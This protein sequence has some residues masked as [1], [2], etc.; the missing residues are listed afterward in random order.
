MRV[1]Y[2]SP[3][4]PERSGIADYSAELL[5]HLAA[6]CELE[7]GLAD[8]VEAD[9]ETTRGLPV[10]RPAE[11]AERLARGDYDVALYQI[12]NDG[13]FHGWIYDLAL[14]YPGVAVLHEVV[15]H[16]LVRHRT[17][18]RGDRAGYV[19]AMRYSYGRGGELAGRRA[20]DTGVPAD[21][22]AFPLFEPIADRSRALLVHNEYC[23]TRI[24]RSRTGARIAVVPHHL[25]LAAPEGVEL[26]SA[27]AR[28]ALGIRPDE[29]VVATFGY[30]TPAKRLEALLRAFAGL[31]AAMPGARL[32]IVGEI[33]P[34]YDIR[35]SEEARQP[36]VTWVGRS[37]LGTFLQW[38]AAADIAV[39]L[40][41]P[42]GGETSGTFVRLLG[43]GKPVIAT[44]AGAFAEVPAGCCALVD[45]GG[46]EVEVVTALLEL[47]ARRADLRRDMGDNARRLAAAWTLEASAAAYDGWLRRC[48]AENWQPRPILPPLAPT[49]SDDVATEVL[50][51]TAAAATDLGVDETDDELLQALALPMTDLNLDNWGQVLK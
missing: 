13:N 2:A 10:R 7:L 37:E 50:T 46:D 11:L 31:R 12:G 21:P 25:S 38:M 23:R 24:Q 4:A 45:P 17:L 35:G 5:P 49:N 14:R 29:L 16:H 28:T 42:T 8:G 1:A 51:H 22:Y 15:L 44:R 6:R 36:G 9:R 32:V 39:N 3:L 40:R 30:V 43:L 20:V 19:E 34:R 33:A 27:T 18:G 48:A 41:W 26:A 47:L